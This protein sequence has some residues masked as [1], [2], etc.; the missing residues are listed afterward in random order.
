MIL[1]GAKFEMKFAKRI[2]A[3]GQSGSSWYFKKFNHL[4]VI[5]VYREE[6]KKL[7]LNLKKCIF[8]YFFL[9]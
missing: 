4:T 3:N 6:L 8:G 7:V 2:I 5:V 9:L 1:L